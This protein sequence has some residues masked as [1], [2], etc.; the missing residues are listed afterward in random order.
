MAGRDG[1]ADQIF[2]LILIAMRIFVYLN[3]ETNNEDISTEM[4]IVRNNAIGMIMLIKVLMIKKYL[5]HLDGDHSRQKIA[6]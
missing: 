3:L 2:G 1:A 6:S 4:L 5:D